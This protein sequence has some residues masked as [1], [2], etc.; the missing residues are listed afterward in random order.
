MSHLEKKCQL[1]S[2]F[3][4]AVSDFIR[5]NCEIDSSAAAPCSV[6]RSKYELTKRVHRGTMLKVVTSFQ[7]FG[8]L[9]A[10]NY[11]ERP[12]G[13][14]ENNSMPYILFYIVRQRGRVRKGV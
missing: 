7:N 14:I 10:Y 1:R 6:A 11:V 5:N 9:F 2:V 12:F 13:R 8:L 3:F 4:F